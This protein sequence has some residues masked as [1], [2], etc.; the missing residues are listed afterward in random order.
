M[1][2]RLDDIEITSN[3]ELTTPFQ[4]ITKNGE[5]FIA[6]PSNYEKLVEENYF[7]QILNKLI[8]ERVYS[9]VKVE[10]TFVSR[11]KMGLPELMFL[12]AYAY[13]AFAKELVT[14]PNRKTQVYHGLMSAQK[15]ILT[16]I[17]NLD[18]SLYKQ[19]NAKTPSTVI[20]GDPYG[21]N[22][23]VEKKILDKLTHLLRTNK[24][25]IN[26]HANLIPANEIIKDKGLKVNTESDLIT[27]NEQACA[28]HILNAI[29][30]FAIPPAN[31]LNTVAKAI[32][33]QN[34]ILNHQKRLKVI[35]SGLSTVISDRI[36]ACF[37]PYKSVGER[38]RAKKEKIQ[39]LIDNAESD[40]EQRDRFNPSM[41]FLFVGLQRRFATIPSDWSRDRY[42]EYMDATEALLIQHFG[43][44]VGEAVMQEY[45]IFL[46]NE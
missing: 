24:Y 9:A 41:V 30:D 2:S 8:I 22:Y 29:G 26:F 37:A 17:S 15:V 25:S 38:N 6:L 14:P 31:E 28:N 23:P 20:F 34:T 1:P 18:I 33:F 19:R 27:E 43:Q 7:F 40:P 36:N 12:K 21:K 39:T 46:H 35:K 3:K 5:T 42:S 45:N 44:N 13:Q 10:K 11:L 16:N 4:T 32:E